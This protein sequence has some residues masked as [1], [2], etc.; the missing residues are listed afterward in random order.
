MGLVG[1][2]PHFLTLVEPLP[3]DVRVGAVG[4][5]S[6]G[7]ARESSKAETASL[8]V[9]VI[10]VTS[11]DELKTRFGPAMA[12]LDPFGGLWV[13]WPKQSSP[14]ATSLKESHV[15]AHGSAPSMRTGQD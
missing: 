13:A 1:A 7:S 2:P 5:R 6:A 3:A 4:Q 15:R 14:L 8:D 12:R 11:L 10:F 9:Q